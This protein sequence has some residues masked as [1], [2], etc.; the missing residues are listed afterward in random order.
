MQTVT[1]A[2]S[3]PIAY[4][5]AGS[6]PAIILVNGALTT[7]ASGSGPALAAALSRRM[8][9]FSY[10][11]RGRGGSGDTLPYAVEREIE[12]LGAV[13]Q[14]AG[15][16]AMLFG[17]S[18]GA[19]LAMRAAVSLGTAVTGLALYEAPY[20]DD[21]TDRQTWSR[22][23]AEL[24][25]TLAGGRRGDALALFMSLVGTP[26][27]QIEQMRSAPFWVG[28]EGIAPTLAY[29]HAGVIGPDLGVPTDL[30]SQVAVP[31]LVMYGTSS[32]PFMETTA[33]TLAGIIPGATLLP[34]EGQTHE[35][36]PD[37][38]AAAILDHMAPA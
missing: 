1:S 30:A 18:S 15:G 17:H 22:Y 8:T 34:M 35:V 12:D 14:A 3:T 19:C 32:F 9:V 5:R 13:I 23:L 6:G 33:R 16:R 21:A 38:L 29:D 25:T 4:D 7:R 36:Q 24:E 10:D 11:R 20:N 28:L 37:P 31:T 27:A 26:A 2:D